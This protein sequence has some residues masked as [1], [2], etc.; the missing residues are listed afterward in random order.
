MFVDELTIVVRSGAGGRGCE[1]YF[2]RAD[3]KKIPNG[4]DGGNGGDIIF[5]TDPHMANLLSLRSKPDFEAERGEN[6]IGNNKYG[7]NGKDRIIS[8]PCGTTLYNKTE[9]LLIRDLVAPDEEIVVLTGGNG[10]YGNH[11]KRPSTSGEPAKELELLLSFKI[12]TDI[13]LVG[14]PNAGKTA[15]LKKITNAHLEDTYYPFAT[16]TPQLGTYQTDYGS[17][18]ICEIPSVYK[19]SEVGHGLGTHYL[20]HMERAKLVFLMLDAKTEFAEDL[21]MG[22]DILMET[23]EGFNSNFTKIPRFTVVNK[24]DLV[25]PKFN[26]KKYFPKKERVY[27]VSILKGTGLNQLLKDAVKALEK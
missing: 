7:R 3:H 5:K 13:V 6:G 15:L 11:S 8:V 18:R 12:I 20:K 23:I 24:M 16:K 14:L 10:G 1:S 4:G 9:N 27:P 26:V 22:Y 21:G 19:A 17:F 25:A 2:K